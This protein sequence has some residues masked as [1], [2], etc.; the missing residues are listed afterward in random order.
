MFTFARYV[1]LFPP[2][3][4]GFRGRSFRSPAVPHLYRYY[5]FVRPL[6]IRGQAPTVPLGARVTDLAS[7][8][9]ELSWGS[10][11]ILLEACPELGTP[12]T[13]ARP[14]NIGRPDNNVGPSNPF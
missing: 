1:H 10:W 3:S 5:G 8:D 14:R 13:P 12:A 9:G 6:S 2:P 7:E 11:G 4:S